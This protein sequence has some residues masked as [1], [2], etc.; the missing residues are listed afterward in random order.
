MH[1]LK[2]TYWVQVLTIVVLLNMVQ[3]SSGQTR[4]QDTEDTEVVEI[5]V[6]FE[7]RK[8]INKDIF[9]QHDG[10]NIY[11]P[12]I[13]IFQLLELYV[14]ADFQNLRFSGFFISKKD[15]YEIDLLRHTARA[16]GQ[17]H[18]L[19]ASDYFLMP[20]ELYLR[21]D[22][23][24]QLFDLDMEFIFSTLQVRLP[25]NEDFPSY[26]KLER[27]KAQVKL[28]AKKEVLKDIKF[29]HRK[30]EMF[31]GGVADWV[32]SASPIGGGGH[33]YDLATGGMILGGDIYVAGGGNTI[34]GFETDKLNYKWHY[35][36]NDNR[37]FTQAELGHIFTGGLLS[38]SLEGGLITSRPQ[39]QRKYFQTI[40]LSGNPGEG[41]EVELYINNQLADF[42]YTDHTGGYN[43]VVDINYGVTEIILKMYGP[44]GELK[45]E[46][47][48]IG[49]PYNL[50]SEKSYEYTL[51]IGKSDGIDS[52]NEYLQ[53]SGLYGLSDKSTVGLSSDLPLS[54]KDGEMSTVAGEATYQVDG[55]LT[56]NTSLAPGYAFSIAQN[57]RHPKLLSFNSSFTRYFKN[58]N[59]NKLNL[60][61][62]LSFS[63]S[64][65]VR[66]GSRHYSL[67]YSFSWNKFPGMNSINM[68]YGFNTSQFR[69]YF[70]Y[71]G[72]YKISKYPDRSVKN[73]TS[74]LFI[75]P[76]YF[77]WIRPQLRISYDHTLNQ[78]TQYGIYLNK[79]VFKT[80]Q[81][82]LTFERHE[83]SKSYQVGVSLKFWRDFAD[84][85]SRLTY[86]D[87]YLSM[88]QVQKGSIRYDQDA[89][90]FW[91]DR[92]KAVG[93]GSA[94]VR[95]FLDDNYNGV[96]DEDEEYLSGLKAKIKGGRQKRSGK[97]QQYYYYYDGLRAY[98]QYT[99]QIDKYSLN[100]PLLT[101]T[102]ENYKV[103]CNP[104]IVTAIN[105][106]LV[107][108]SDI[109]GQIERQVADMKTGQ[110]GIKVMI[111]N[112]SKESVT[113]IT[114]FSNGQFYYLGL[115]PGLYR[116]YIDPDQLKKYGYISEP[117]GI[118]FD[119][120]P[121]EGGTSIENI[122]FVLLPAEQ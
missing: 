87:N 56:L 89:H 8:L 54:S 17:K 36:F 24:K 14:E 75:A 5:V 18:K 65:P 110:G 73:V 38:R 114:T 120:K 1:R 104:N 4:L 69:V 97:D 48:Y 117:S 12:L 78:V 81:L 55:N 29:L 35:F 2:I 82:A 77:Q 57:Y 71:I 13:D 64:S 45:T 53:A 116:V 19:L 76:Q 93:Y 41:W 115:I 79:R 32:I 21:I 59:R 9:A 58:S 95:P 122:N 3:L 47:Q 118:E 34:T 102:H 15:K 72:R 33:Y 80:G 94:V 74:K 109:S 63:A 99:I 101:P 103:Y 83:T 43:F 119:I 39:V 121:V 61:H 67:R 28:K 27:H 68:N 49:V 10:T 16:R 46:R 105:V 37:Y 107:T 66:I 98:D 90:R 40:D 50:I 52:N 6:N 23:F 42:A 70:N 60:V 25:L 92:R 88:S 108:G 30:R 51:A 100:N 7:V 62:N 84:F 22:L 86:S 112:I 85:A 20:H 44:N 11:L 113:E 111:L 31:G 106:P 91:F 26:K 96:L